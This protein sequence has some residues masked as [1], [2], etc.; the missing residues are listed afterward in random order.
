MHPVYLHPI[1]GDKQHSPKVTHDKSWLHPAAAGHKLWC[2]RALPKQGTCSPH[3]H[4]A[5]MKH[6][7]YDGRM[8]SSDGSR[9]CILQ[10][11]GCVIQNKTLCSDQP[12]LQLCSVPAWRLLRKR[13]E[14]PF[15]HSSHNQ[16]A[17]IVGFQP[18]AK[19]TLQQSLPE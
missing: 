1:T 11:K 13:R 3:H 16:A 10:D 19:Q 9:K 5:R 7:S 15:P 6:S 12:L 17:F 4:T 8:Q 2:R 14:L 18:S